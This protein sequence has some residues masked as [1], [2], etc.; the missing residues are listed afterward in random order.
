[1]ILEALLVFFLN[2]AI[3]MRIDRLDGVGEIVWSDDAALKGILKGFFEELALKPKSSAF[4]EPLNVC[5]R[6][7]LLSCRRAD[8]FD[9][10]HAIVHTYP[11]EAPELP[12]IRQRL[13]KHVED[14]YNAIRQS[15]QV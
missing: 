7:H 8:F 4:A 1:M 9:L 12:I 11:S 10:N 2:M 3:K 14:L 5:F 15:T 6:Q 13:G